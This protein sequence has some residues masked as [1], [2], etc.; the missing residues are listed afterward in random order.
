MP[1]AAR[2]LF[3]TSC[4]RNYRNGPGTR[5]SK[6]PKSAFIDRFGP[7]PDEQPSHIQPPFPAWPGRSAP[8]PDSSRTTKNYALRVPPNL[9]TSIDK[10][11]EKEKETSSWTSTSWRKGELFSDTIGNVSELV[12]TASFEARLAIQP[13]METRKQQR[14]AAKMSIS[15]QLGSL[16]P[17]ATASGIRAQLPRQFGGHR[18]HGAELRRFAYGKI[19]W[20]I[21]QRSIEGKLASRTL[22]PHLTGTSYALHNLRWLNLAHNQT[23]SG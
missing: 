8:L 20:L 17:T 6:T 7:P 21:N 1:I 4:G 15:R 9:L 23:P 22:P 19:A 10:P 14:L 16:Q 5:H 3:A 11:K 2:R 18:D 12:K 13:A